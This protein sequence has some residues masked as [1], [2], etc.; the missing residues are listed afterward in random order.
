VTLANNH[1]L[2]FGVEA[3][4]DTLGVLASAGIATAGA[5]MNQGDARRPAT[6][7]SAGDRMEV[8]AV[9]D[10]PSDFA[11]GPDRP[12]IAFA[13]LRRAVPDW[14]LD[15]IRG[16]T[17]DMIVVT[18]HWGPNMT[19]EPVRHVRETARLLAGAGASL[20]AGHS[21]H[22]FHGVGDRVLYDLGD[23]MDDYAVDPAL[24]NDLG[25]LWLVDLGPSGPRHLEA[26]PLKL[27]YC[28]TGPA[29]G[30]DAAEVT[31]R[32]REACRA[33]GTEVVEDDGRLV[34]RWRG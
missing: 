28:F 21:A 25:I 24:R 16:S 22:V 23:F 27:D 20:V 8:F 34:V 32:F 13:D 18:P 31:R 1:A 12:G 6:L 5:G 3:L 15:A 14:L 17:G 11:A 2:D 30:E 7:G 19:P 26:L 33:L 10:H 4:E 29:R 9:A